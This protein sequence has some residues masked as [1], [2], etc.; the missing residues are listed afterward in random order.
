MGL[1]SMSMELGSEVTC[2][3]WR[4]RRFMAGMWPQDVPDFYGLQNRELRERGSR[5]YSQVDGAG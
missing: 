3:C 4:A 1:H 2:S 5:V